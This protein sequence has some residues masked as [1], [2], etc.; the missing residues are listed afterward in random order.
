MSFSDA[1]PSQANQP[2]V[3]NTSQVIHVWEGAVCRL[4]VVTSPDGIGPAPDQLDEDWNTVLVEVPFGLWEV[5][6]DRET[7]G[8][9]TNSPDFGLG[10]GP[11]VRVGGNVNSSIQPPLINRTRVGDT[12]G[13]R[14]NFQVS[15]HPLP[16]EQTIWSIEGSV[17]EALQLTRDWRSGAV[18]H[19]KASTLTTTV[20]ASDPTPVAF[21]QSAAGVAHGR[22][23]SIANR[24]SSASHLH[25]V[26][27]IH[28]TG[29]IVSRDRDGEDNVWTLS[30]FSRTNEQSGVAEA[31]AWQAN[32]IV[33]VHVYAGPNLEPGIGATSIASYL[34]ERPS[35]I[36]GSGGET[37]LE[38]E[39]ATD[40]SRSAGSPSWT[41]RA[42]KDGH[43]GL[44]DFTLDDAEDAQVSARV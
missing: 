39:A 4:H 32:A 34:D 15:L 2:R 3:G 35:V 22:S 20:D 33:K 43:Q 23:G 24:R 10:S 38:G 40:V 11:R 29:W 18:D 9:D 14:F 5:S 17:D 37:K 41:D 44:D 7:T 36:D 27:V 13:D 31:C 16:A 6:R 12:G 8:R 25:H 28:D 19:A 30:I 26:A 42:T 1:D 21:V